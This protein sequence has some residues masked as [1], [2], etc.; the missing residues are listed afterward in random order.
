MKGYFITLEGI[1]GTGK[2]TA[3]R[4]LAELLANAKI[5]HIVTREPGGTEIGDQIRRVLLSHHHEIMAPDAELLLMFASRAQNLATLIKPT[6]AEGKWVLCD[7]FT[8]ASYAYQG[9]GRG[10]AA[11][12]I[13]L[14]EEWVQQDLRPDLVLIFDAPV[15]IGLSR[16]KQRSTK[17][18]I[19]Y[20]KHEFFERVRCAYLQRAQL[21]PNRY[22]IIDATQSIEKVEEQIQQIVN[23]LLSSSELTS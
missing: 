12:R 7:R 16:I 11:A 13:A 22:R 14:L 10:I 4:F 6:L 1:E 2:S 17:D 19:E 23:S 21:N 15:E 3:L 9:G 5:P 8:D 18:R 20:E